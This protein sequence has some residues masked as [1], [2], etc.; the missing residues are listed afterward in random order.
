MTWPD[1]YHV[2][3]PA[4]VSIQAAALGAEM[5]LAWADG[6]VGSSLR[7]KITDCAYTL[8]TTYGANPLF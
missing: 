8:A 3:F 4:T 7:T 2:P 6:K 1:A 5:A